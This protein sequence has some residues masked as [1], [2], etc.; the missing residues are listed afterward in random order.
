MSQYGYFGI[1]IDPHSR[2]KGVGR[3]ALDLL[4]G[5]AQQR[6]LKKLLAE[7]RADNA[8][9]LDLCHKAGFLSVGVLRQHYRGHS[10]V[11]LE[12]ML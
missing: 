11:L 2:R 10:V 7:V 6:G 5:E 12:R 3:R 9:S 1:A 4:I 8:A